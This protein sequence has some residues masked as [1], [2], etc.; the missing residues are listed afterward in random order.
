MV[1]RPSKQTS[2]SKK[3]P[4]EE[5]SALKPVPDIEASM[6]RILGVNGNMEL[7]RLAV[8]PSLL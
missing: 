5:L 4:D 1:I 6:P 3:I 2:L 7:T 8:K